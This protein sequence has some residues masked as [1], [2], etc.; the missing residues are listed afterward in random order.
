MRGEL[1]CRKAFTMRYI[2][3]FIFFADDETAWYYVDLFSTKENT[4]IWQTGLNQPLNNDQEKYWRGTEPNNKDEN[5]VA[6]R[7]DHGGKFIDIMCQRSCQFVCVS[8]N[9][10]CAGE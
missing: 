2:F 3:I 4:W 10:K 9:E 8:K 6:I 5:C 1:F 7:K